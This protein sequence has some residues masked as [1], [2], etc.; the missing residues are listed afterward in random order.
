MNAALSVAFDAGALRA[1]T[2]EAHRLSHRLL[3]H[4]ELDA[5]EAKRQ[6]SVRA[7][8]GRGNLL[9][10]TGRTSRVSG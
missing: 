7:R 8:A 1:A 2:R 3:M 5:Y 9:K 10:A 6:R 4:V